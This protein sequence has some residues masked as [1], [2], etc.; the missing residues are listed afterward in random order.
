M[1]SL[2]TSSGFIPGNCIENLAGES[3][4]FSTLPE[5]LRVL[6]T[7]DGT[8]T[9]ILEA[10]FWEPVR[11]HSVGQ[12]FINLE[13][14]E[15]F[16]HSVGGDRVLHRQ[17][18]LVGRCSKRVFAWAHSLIRMDVL[19]NTIA[20]KLEQDGL[21]IGELLRDCGLETYREIIDFGLAED[22]AWRTYRIVMQTKPFIKITEQF[23]LNIY[24]VA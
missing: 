16:I 10:Y 19:P 3:I 23:P 2:F 20:G 17:V 1:T 11:V 22:M 6:L 8:V 4:D 18:E 9:K 7:T 12:T 5:F 24:R 15:P 21:G 14:D 13:A